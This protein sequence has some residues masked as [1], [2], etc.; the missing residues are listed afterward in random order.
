MLRLVPSSRSIGPIAQKPVAHWIAQC[1]AAGV[2]CSP[3]HTLEEAL[4]HPQVASRGLVQTTEHP[5]VKELPSV[6][7]PVR[8]EGQPSKSKSAPPLLGQHTV[9]ILAGIGYDAQ[10]IE[11]LCERGVVEAGARGA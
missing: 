7:F 9:E 11:A 2:P 8:F 3:I 10:A 6:A 1:Q 5:D 4:H